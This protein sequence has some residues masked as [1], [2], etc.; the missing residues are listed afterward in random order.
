MQNETV[1]KMVKMV[2][3]L[4]LTSKNTNGSCLKMEMVVDAQT[5]PWQYPHILLQLEHDEG[6]RLTS[7]R[8]PRDLPSRP[9][10]G[11]Q[12]GLDDARE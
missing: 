9:G 12:C 10:L 8:S 5:I 4:S 11:Q 2:V 7:P 6:K 1:A 3:V